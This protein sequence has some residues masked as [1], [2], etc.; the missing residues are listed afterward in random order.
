MTESSL[1]LYL[2]F[3]HLTGN[4]DEFRT[5]CLYSFHIIKLIKQFCVSLLNFLRY[6]VAFL[7]STNFLFGTFDGNFV[8][9]TVSGDTATPAT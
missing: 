3:D 4:F 1:T 8:L 9:I 7:F 5:Y 2:N 6:F